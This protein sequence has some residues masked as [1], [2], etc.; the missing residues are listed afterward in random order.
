MMA[1][2]DRFISS[3]VPIRDGVLVALRVVVDRVSRAGNS[4]AT[5][6]HSE[7]SAGRLGLLAGPDS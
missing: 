1:E 6:V 2:D 4:A 7:P 3:I 5:S